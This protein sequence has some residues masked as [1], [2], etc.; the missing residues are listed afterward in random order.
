MRISVLVLIGAVLLS[1]LVSWSTRSEGRTNLSESAD[2]DLPYFL[3]ISPE[4]ANNKLDSLS[5]DEKIAQSFMVA[6]TPNKGEEHLLQIDSL[7]EKYKIGGIIM[8]QG[9]RANTTAA[10]SRLQSKAEIPLL[11]GMDA[12]WGSAM[13]LW[14][15]K[16]YPFQLTMGAA[17]DVESTEIIAKAI[18]KE[19]RDL[20]VHINF[21]PVVDVNSNPD[22]PVIGFRSTPTCS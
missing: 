13:R 22:N 2:R 14:K 11:V 7:V 4:W 5:L 8:F 15:E 18:G 10:I 1:S 19:L 16:K 17:D 12:E 9:D 21:S 3:R 6:V 20:G